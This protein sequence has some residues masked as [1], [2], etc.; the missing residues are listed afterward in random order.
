M[1]EGHLTLVIERNGERAAEIGME[2][3]TSMPW[4]SG[5][6]TTTAWLQIRRNGSIYRVSNKLTF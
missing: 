1:P 6:D 4:H 5:N 2:N 3:D